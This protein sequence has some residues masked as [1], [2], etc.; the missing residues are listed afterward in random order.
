MFEGE[1]IKPQRDSDAADEGGVILADQEHGGQLQLMRL[2]RYD[3][4]LPEIGKGASG[5]LRQT[6]P[7]MGI[8]RDVLRIALQVAGRYSAKRASKSFSNSG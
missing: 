6:I 3:C 1:A 4:R 2:N 7:L 8:A 5:T